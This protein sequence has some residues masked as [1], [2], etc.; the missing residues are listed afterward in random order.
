MPISLWQMNSSNRSV[1]RGSCGLRLASGETS[2]GCI[3]MKVGWISF[4]ST[5]WSKTLVE[6]VAPGVVGGRGQLDADGLGRGHGLVV[7]AM[8]H[9]VHAGVLLHRLDHRQAGPAGGQVDRW[10]CQVS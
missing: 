1:R 5:F 10:P 4:S 8:A 7:E 3:V 2:T 9:E 6:G